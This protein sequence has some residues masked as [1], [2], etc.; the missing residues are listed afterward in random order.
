M[1]L[2]RAVRRGDLRE[3]QN[4]I[5]QGADIHVGDDRALINAVYNGSV[6]VVEFLLNH[7][8][9]IH[10][11]DDQ[12]LIEAVTLGVSQLSNSYLTMEQISMLRMIGLLFMQL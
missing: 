1:E 5:N 12:A 10:A 9:N 2:I 7:G 8:A 6:S 3:V 11:Q 4:L